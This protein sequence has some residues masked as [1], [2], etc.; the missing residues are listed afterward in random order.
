MPSDPQLLLFLAGLLTGIASALIVSAG[1]QQL[2][3][4]RYLQQRRPRKP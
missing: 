1:Y 2:Q 3:I 4:V